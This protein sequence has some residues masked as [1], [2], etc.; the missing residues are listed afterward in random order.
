MQLFIFIVSMTQKFRLEHLSE[1]QVDAE[2]IP[3]PL[4]GII[5]PRVWVVWKKTENLPILKIFAPR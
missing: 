5:S 4:I 3:A 2:S 1:E